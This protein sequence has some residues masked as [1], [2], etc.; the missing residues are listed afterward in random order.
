MGRDW[1][2]GVL[3]P[4]VGGRGPG[5]ALQLLPG[6]C[7]RLCLPSLSRSLGGAAAGSWDGSPAEDGV[8][9][10]WTG[11]FCR[12]VSVWPGRPPERALQCACPAGGGSA[13]FWTLRDTEFAEVFAG[14]MHRTLMAGRLFLWASLVAQQEGIQC[15]C[16][17]TGSVPGSG[18][19]PGEG[20]GNPLQY[21]CLENLTDG[22][23]CW[24][25]VHGVAK[26]RTQLSDF[27]LTFTHKSN[28]EFC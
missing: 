1:G 13:R 28:S 10:T 21:S 19:S 7:C 9:L 16:G 14:F 8:G 2:A 24:A 12:L 20:L 6:P 25:T 15:R 23:A 11:L 3:T 18:R 22:G 27:T 17:D 4:A 5:L 26:S